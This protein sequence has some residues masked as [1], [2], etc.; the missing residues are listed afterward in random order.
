MS[1]QDDALVRLRCRFLLIIVPMLKSKL[2]LKFPND[3]GAS[4]TAIASRK[5]ER[6][7]WLV[8]SGDHQSLTEHGICEGNR[9]GRQRRRP[10]D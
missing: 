2:V 8:S 6:L 10:S 4:L 5:D 7:E 1:V 3:L 9:S